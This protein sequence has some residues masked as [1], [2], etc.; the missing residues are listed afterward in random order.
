MVLMAT[1]TSGLLEILYVDWVSLFSD[2][3]GTLAAGVGALYADREAT[4]VSDV[5]QVTISLLVVKGWK[6]IN[7]VLFLIFACVSMPM[8]HYTAVPLPLC[9][10]FL[11]CCW[12]DLPLICH[13][14]TWW[15]GWSWTWQCSRGSA[16]WR[17]VGWAH[18]LVGHLCSVW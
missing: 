8:W 11:R 18:S 7:T 17:A 1:A 9:S 14:Q 13:L 12:W 10:P 15:C 2:E 3:K 5:D 4:R 6:V 16:V